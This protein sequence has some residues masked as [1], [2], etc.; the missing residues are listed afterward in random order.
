M[1][2]SN[3]RQRVAP[4]IMVVPKRKSSVAHVA[5]SLVASVLLVLSSPAQDRQASP[6][7][8]KAVGAISAINSNTITVKKDDGSEVNV[9]AQESTRLA[10]IAPGQK[11]LKSATPIQLRDLQV[12][13]RILV[14]GSSS[15]EKTITAALKPSS[16]RSDKIGSIAASAASLPVS[17]PAPAQS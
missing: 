9:Q 6:A 8:S 14:R 16:R 17:T 2:A 15:D 7:G 1:T 4:E 11:D 3:L 12:G 5:A 13:D 10:R